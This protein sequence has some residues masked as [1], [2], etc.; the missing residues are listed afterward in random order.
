M[1]R[2]R[3][4][5][6]SAEPPARTLGGMSRDFLGC[7]R[8]LRHALP[9]PTPSIEVVWV[10]FMGGFKVSISPAHHGGRVEQFAKE[11]SPR[12]CRSVW[13]EKSQVQ[14]WLS[15]SV[16][17][18]CG[19]RSK[20]KCQRY[21]CAS[22]EESRGTQ[23]PLRDQQTCLAC[24]SSASPRRNRCVPVGRRSTCCHT[25]KSRGRDK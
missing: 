22:S 16:N 25:C 8:Q 12:R 24:L 23:G 6:H 2:T 11:T 7:G 14:Q 3:F 10:V 4:H 15:T 1:R 20:T 19:G 17:A 5:P 13:T 18:R 9:L 21:D